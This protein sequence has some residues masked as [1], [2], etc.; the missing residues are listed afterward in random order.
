MHIVWKKMIFFKLRLSSFKKK[1]P[2]LFHFFCNPKRVLPE[3]KLICELF[4][5]ILSKIKGKIESMVCIV[6]LENLVRDVAHQIQS[7]YIQLHVVG[8][9]N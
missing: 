5:T 7:T 2:V 3:I 8:T 9:T 1:Q 6:F 4:K